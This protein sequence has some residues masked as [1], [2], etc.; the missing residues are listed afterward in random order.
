MNVG[1]RAM[2]TGRP[3]TRGYILIEAAMAMAVLS[4]GVF[5]IQAAVREA[6]FV[7]GLARDYTQARFL[8]DNVLSELELQT[9]LAPQSESGSLGGEYARFRIKWDVERL[10][11]P[12]PEL[13]FDV[14]PGE[15]KVFI[16]PYLAKVRASVTWKRRGKEFKQIAETLLAPERLY[17]T[18]EELD[19]VLSRF[20]F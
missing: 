11:L 10:D 9:E 12:V 16:V 8:I 15:A 6:L 13:P 20:R 2:R 17:V 4:A 7:R 5:S 14:D 18:E 3:R 19:E 1:R